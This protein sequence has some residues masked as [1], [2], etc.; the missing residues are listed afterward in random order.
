MIFTSFIDD[1]LCFI[2]AVS[3]SRLRHTWQK[4]YN[5]SVANKSDQR[6]RFRFPCG[7]C[8]S[9]FS[10]KHNLQ[11]HLRNECGQP[12]SFSCPYCVYRMRH[13]SNMRKHVRRVHPG[14]PVYVVDIRKTEVF[15]FS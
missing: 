13:P 12:P 7:N 11:H 3:E 15:Q 6:V 8:S 1:V 4:S 9:V 10:L 2:L 5:R 14:K